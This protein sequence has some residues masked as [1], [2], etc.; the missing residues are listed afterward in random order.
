[1]NVK[2]I[3]VFSS[4]G[5]ISEL[6][7]EQIAARDNVGNYMDRYLIQGLER[8]KF[9]TLLL[10][11]QEDKSETAYLLEV[12][13]KD[14]YEVPRAARFWGG[15]MAGANKLNLHYDFFDLK[16][17]NV[18]SWDDGVGSTKSSNHCAQAL[19]KRAVKKIAT[20]FQENK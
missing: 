18:L 3:A 17:N 20:Y 4:R 8:K 2:E 19:N 9:N 1:D 14:L 15:R 6:T 7:P 13:I 16:G 10:K 11:A 5:D 12:T